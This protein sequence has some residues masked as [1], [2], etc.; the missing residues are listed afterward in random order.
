MKRPPFTEA[1]VEYLLSLDAV[2]SAD[3]TRIFYTPDFKIAAIKLYCSGLGPAEIFRRAGMPSSLVGYKRGQKALER[4]RTD[5]RC[6]LVPGFNAKDIDDSLKTYKIKSNALSMFKKDELMEQDERTFYEDKIKKLEAEVELLKEIG[7]RNCMAAKAQAKQTHQKAQTFNLI[8]EKAKEK[9]LSVKKLCFLL[10]VSTSGYYKWLNSKSIRDKKE[11]SDLELKELIIKA[12]K[13]RN[14]KKGTRQVK[15]CLQRLFNV[16]KS[17]HCLQRVMRKYN[18]LEKPKRKRP[19]YPIAC[20]G[21]PKV[22]DNILNRNFRSGVVNKYFATDLTYIKYGSGNCYLSAVIDLQSNLVV[23]YKVSTSLETKFVEETL[24]QLK[25]INLAAGALI[26]SDQGSQYT[27]LAYRKKLKEL[28]LIQSMS[29][30]GNCHDNACIESFFGRLK[31]QIGNTK[32]LGLKK[33]QALIDDY[34]DYYNNERGQARL[35]WKTPKEY[36]TNFAA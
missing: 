15:D 16:R 28:G 8:A 11:A 3:A 21:E 35:D 36:A 19:Y 13:V 25:P 30:K 7:F 29:R 1:E 14:T 12:K 6:G 23:G 33:I 32:K 22:A 26:H 34:I 5:A 31:E 20:D 27:S 18:L 2:K 9:I 17:R 4:W 10:D 24:D